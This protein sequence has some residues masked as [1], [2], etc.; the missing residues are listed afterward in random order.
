MKKLGILVIVFLLVLVIWHSGLFE[1]E[2]VLD[3]LEA[4]IRGAIGLLERG[5][6]FLIDK[7]KSWN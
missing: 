3:V 2:R 5:V 1:N 6:N 7:L 4:G